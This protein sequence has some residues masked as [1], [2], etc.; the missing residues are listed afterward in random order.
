MGKVRVRYSKIAKKPVVFDKKNPKN[1]K[2]ES[3]K[4]MKINKKTN[5]QLKRESF[6]RLIEKTVKERVI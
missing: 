5:I 1:R 4:I 6:V 3:Y 2:S